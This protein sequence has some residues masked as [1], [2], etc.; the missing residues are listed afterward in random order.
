MAKKPLLEQWNATHSADLYGIN[1]WGSGYFGVSENG[2][3]VITPFAENGPAVS[4]PDVIKGLQ[5]RGMDLPVLLR[6]ENILDAQITVLHDCF[7]AA[8]REFGYQGEFRGVFPIKVN[9]Q[10]QVVEKIAQY[11]QRHHHGLEVGSKA[12][13]I[14]AL[15]YLND[16]EACIVCNGYKDAEFVDLALYGTKMGY[17]CILVLEMPSELPLILARS[18]V[19]GVRPLIGVRIK[20]SSRAGGHWTESGGDLS[21]FG[22]STAEVVDA[23]DLLRKEDMLDCMRLLHFHLG[24]QIPNI[25]DIREALREAC[26]VYA[27]LVDEGAAMGYLDLGGGLA[28][29]YD[30]SHTNFLSSRNYTLS[31]YCA[32]IVETVM[33]ILDERE[34]AHPHIIT[35]SGRATVAYYSVLLFNILD[36]SRLEDRA[37]PVDLPEDCPEPTEN[38]LEVYN[39]ISLKNLQEC[40]NDAIYYRDEIRQMFR[41]GNCT[42]RERG[43]AETIFWAI[44]KEIAQRVDEV[45]RPTVELAGIQDSLASIYYANMSVFQS[46]PDSWAIDHLFPV[47]PVHRLKEQPTEKVVLADITCDCDGKLD[48]FIDPRGVKR[49][50]DLHELKNG[51]PYY[52]GAFLVGAYQETLGDLHNLFGDTNVASIHIN[53]DGSFDFVREL[54]GD[55]VA[56]VLSYV[57]Y[58]PKMVLERFRNVA[59]QGVREGRISPQDRYSIMKAFEN[60]LRGYTYL[61]GLR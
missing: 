61:N 48:R 43:V 4:I 52:L 50:L 1:S 16:H 12:E 25:R 18:K 22:L 56:D 6:V 23:L 27:G 2:D 20:L 21:I 36:A 42:L 34:I 29:D 47:M 41:L 8:I 26:R 39:S 11:G 51:D 57:E 44:I 46:L 3:V 59:E 15:S 33:S 19:L 60:G 54:D 31:E 13:L 28:V 49:T 5:D 14:A 35:E 9:Q 38:L 53:E 32:D 37:L 45:K 40:Y 7:R 55:S 17:K 24:S 10:E 58:D 30:G